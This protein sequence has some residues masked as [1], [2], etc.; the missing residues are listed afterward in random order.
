M[1]TRLIDRLTRLEA[2]TAPPSMGKHLTFQVEAPR[3]TPVGDIVTFLKDQGHAIHGDD[4]V[5]V[6]NLGG[7]EQEGFAPLRDLSAGVFT[8]DQRAAAPAA[9]KW[10][11]GCSAFTFNLDSPGGAR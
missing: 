7:H 10:P 11:K 8:E 6:M 2:A 9:G 4:D 1:T 5:L 3:G